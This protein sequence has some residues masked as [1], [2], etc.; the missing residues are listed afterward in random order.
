MPKKEI[1]R[2]CMS[3][4]E[5]QSKL[6]AIRNG[7][8]MGSPA[9]YRKLE[10]VLRSRSVRKFREFIIKHKMAGK[11]SK[12][13]TPLFMDYLVTKHVNLQDMEPEARARLRGVMVES[14]VDEEMTDDYREHVEQSK[15]PCTCKDC[16]YFME[17]PEDEGDDA[18][19][20]VAM[21]AKGIDEACY[22]F[23]KKSVA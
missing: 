15:S 14:Q 13:L 10:K 11:I 22:G 4:P 18:K 2:L 17:A 7:L 19:H 1:H 23:T 9:R 21:G 6:D 5:L 16:R 12:E 20:C 8:T 3:D